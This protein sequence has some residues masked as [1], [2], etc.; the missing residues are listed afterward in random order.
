MDYTFDNERPIYMQLCEK[1]R[2]EIISKNMKP[3]EKLPS[4]RE[5]AVIFRVN[6]NTVVKALSELEVEKLIYTE[7]TN[8]KFITEDNDLIEKLK[9]KFAKELSQK[10]IKDMENIGIGKKDI[11]DILK[12]SDT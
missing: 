10:F 11:I 12:S 4:V 8:G 1:I 9:I 2:I 5:L 6:P 3:G 7:R